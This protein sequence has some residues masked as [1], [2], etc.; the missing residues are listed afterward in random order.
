MRV[1]SLEIFG[2]KSFAQKILLEFPHNITIIVGPNGSGKSN[3]VDAIKW[4]LGDQSLKSMRINDSRDVIFKNQ[5]KSLNF[6][7]VR[8]NFDDEIVIERKIFR[9][10]T[11]EYLVNGNPVKLKDLQLVLAKLKL[12]TKSLNIINQGSA[13]IFLKSSPN[14]RYEMI[15]EI[16]GIKEYEFK[17]QEAL[18][19]IEQ[20]KE[21]IKQVKI[22]LQ[23]VRPQ[24][25]FFQK[26]KE[27]AEKIEKIKIE[28][29]ELYNEYEIAKFFE[30]SK[31]IKEIESKINELEKQEEELK[32]LLQR[33]EEGITKNQVSDEK[34]KELKDKE[35]KIL[36]E[37]NKILSQIVKTKNVLS[38]DSSTLL[39]Q[40]L[41]KLKELLNF[42]DILKIKEEIKKIIKQIEGEKEE[43][44]ND[45]LDNLNIE[46]EKIR[47]EIR[48]EEN[49]L[50][51]QKID[52]EKYFYEF[53]EYQYKLIKVE[54]ELEHL[55]SAYEFYSNEIKNIKK[56]NRMSFRKLEDLEREIKEKELILN[57]LGSVDE[58]T[59]KEYERVKNKVEKLEND[60]LDLE[61]ALGNLNYF[62]EQIDEKIKNEFSKKMKEINENLNYYFSLI[63]EG[64][65]IKLL[66]K[67]TTK[68][69]DVLIQLPGKKT[70]NVDS[71][72]G[73]E[74]ALTS[75]AIV[76]SLIKTL[77]PIFVILDEIDASLD[78]NNALK[79]A[80][81]IKE[82]SD[83]TQFII[84]SHNRAVMEI[85]QSL[86]G[87]SLSQ[88][89]SSRVISLKL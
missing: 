51:A 60:L 88:D 27:K 1:K 14:Q 8:I 39:S 80:R 77:K 21:N 75:I 41:N 44:K 64:G 9:D 19:K 62:V 42:D 58:E 46:L 52:R 29:E 78:E 85:A 55:R 57:S 68:E 48:K 67:N 71:L 36:E 53:K 81:L 89:G 45:E 18:K 37:K 63:F 12:S 31:K 84:V 32:A 70:S 30:Y 43:E 10:G 56:P 33:Y 20:T 2:F 49:E 4:V 76:C 66:W 69:I 6:C 65:R 50:R 83:S 86:Y 47:E 5:Q 13:D 61:K 35:L 40:I 16:I 59:L 87:V 74:K 23:E 26:E 28:L 72:S 82:L 24:L 17:K 11:S 34:L 79:F 38:K 25:K 7:W 15:L 3:I 54:E 73:G 22:R